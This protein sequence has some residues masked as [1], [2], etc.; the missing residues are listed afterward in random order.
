M[1]KDRPIRIPLPPDEAL[2]DLLKVKPTADMPRP[3]K[4]PK[5]KR[6]KGTSKA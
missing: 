5:T 2:A 3:S 6:K 4:R 1:P